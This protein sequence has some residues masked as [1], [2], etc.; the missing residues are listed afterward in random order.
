VLERRDDGDVV[1]DF[2]AQGN[3][4]RTGSRT[5][6]RYG[7]GGR[8]IEREG[9]RYE[10]DGD[11]FLCRR[12]AA[13]GATWSYR[14]SPSGMLTE[15]AGPDG[16]R[17]AMEYDGFGRRTRKARFEGDRLV[18][19]QRFVW[20][21]DDL[22]HRES[23]LG[24][25][26]TWYWEP[27]THGLVAQESN[28]AMT[29]A[30][31]DHL[32]VP[33]E[34]F[35]LAGECVWRAR[36]DAWGDV[37]CERGDRGDCPW[38]WPGQYDDVDVD[39]ACQR[40]RWYSPQDGLF[41]WSDPLGAHGNAS[42][43]AYV[44]DPLLQI[45]PLGLIQFVVIGENQRGRVVP[46]A[47]NARSAGHGAREIMAEWPRERIYPTPLTDAQL[48][49]SIDFNREWMRERIAERSVFIDVG[50]DTTRAEMSP[51]YRMELEEL[52]RAS[53][54][55]ALQNTTAFSPTPGASRIEMP[56][57]V[58]ATV[59]VPPKEERPPTCG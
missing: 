36:L 1:R 18:E 34:L 12:V 31:A 28:G 42:P 53:Y 48:A 41:L 15:A 43:Y 11:G 57:G 25:L 14:W 23:S 58:H 17:V 2:D 6:R 52:E 24:G 4:Y 21:G 3:P 40:W 45:D 5:D 54:R 7:P 47:R 10:Y 20:D 35:D 59:W 29:S 22:V 27:R 49:D 13:D 39:A 33:T 56:N 50:A 51:W 26:T 46:T 30:A 8:L 55:K 38:R 44:D 9:A 19:A 37:H 16:R 32:D